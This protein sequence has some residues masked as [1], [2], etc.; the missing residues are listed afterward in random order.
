MSGE[1]SPS[2]MLSEAFKLL[3]GKE[4]LKISILLLQTAIPL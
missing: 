3:P 4:S 2:E 1:M